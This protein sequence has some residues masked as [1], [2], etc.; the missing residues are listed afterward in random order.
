MR[1]RIAGTIF[2]GGWLLAASGCGGRLYNVAPLPTQ[3]APD[4]RAQSANGLEIGAYVLGGDASI[5]RFEANLPLS[6]V[7]VVDLRLVNKTAGAI[8]VSALGYDLQD[9]NGIKL[10]PLS[11]K[12]ALDRVMSYYGVR[13][14]PIAARQRTRED[15]ESVAYKPGRPVA[16][17]DERRGVLFYETKRETTNLDGLRFSVKG[18]S[19]PINLTL[20]VR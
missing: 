17:G 18:I 2:L 11:S 6:G 13:F 9:S 20:E 3:P 10:R 7:I 8:D 19:P 5:E 15:Y 14:Y 12:K 4:T 1:K 16:S